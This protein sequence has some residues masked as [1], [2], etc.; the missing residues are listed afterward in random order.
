M[1]TGSTASS[2]LG[3]PRATH[4]IDLVVVLN[5]AGITALLRAFPAPEFYLDEASLRQAVDR[6]DMVNLLHPDTAG[7]IDFWMLTESEFDQSRFA[8]RMKIDYEGVLVNMS[9]P[10]DTILAKLRW[11]VESGGSEK[12]MLDAR[13]VFEIQFPHLDQPYLDLWA[14]KLDVV[15][16]LAEVRRNAN[17]S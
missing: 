13:R 12:Q 10:E 6:G 1:L 9:R 5:A 4:D 2:R 8:R 14:Q 11:A 3:V 17:V 7:K 16:Q 15:Q